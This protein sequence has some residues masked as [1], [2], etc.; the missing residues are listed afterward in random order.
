MVVFLIA[1]QSVATLLKVLLAVSNRSRCLSSLNSF[2]SMSLANSSLA[3]TRF[4][5]ASANETAGYL[6]K[7][8]DV[9]FLLSG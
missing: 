1:N 9:R 3:A 2:G 8:I 6:P 4:F 7:V 5:L